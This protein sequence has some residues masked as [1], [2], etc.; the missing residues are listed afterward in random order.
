MFRTSHL[1]SRIHF[2][3]K[4]NNTKFYCTQK[5]TLN[6]NFVN[7]KFDVK[8]QVDNDD[9]MFPSVKNYLAQICKHIENE[10][11]EITRIKICESS[12]YKSFQLRKLTEEIKNIPELEYLFI[13]DT[14]RDYECT[15]AVKC[16]RFNHLQKCIIETGRYEILEEY[17][18]L[19]L[20]DFPEKLN[21]RNEIGM[22]P[23][24]LVV[25][26]SGS[27]ST[28]KTV[29]ILL[30]HNPNINE[31]DNVGNTSL[32]YAIKYSILSG[33][34]FTIKL[35]L[36]HNADVNAQNDAGYTPLMYA[37][38]LRFETERIIEL[39]LAHGA[40]INLTNKAQRTALSIGLENNIP[41]SSLILLLEKMNDCDIEIYGKKL[42]KCIKDG[43]YSKNAINLA[44]KKCAKSSDLYKPNF[45]F[46]FF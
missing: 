33:S 46:K 38:S 2:L 36:D 45:L 27:R 40:N 22:T 11:S 16:N 18:D 29:E 43:Y 4:V 12:L 26:N 9:N 28:E 31:I 10:Q 3:N 35:L 44:I 37:V 14:N 5:D 41:E 25:I 6:K 30:K 23:L 39:L 20:T 21:Y 7:I 32:M 24:I 17:I 1:K 8:Y 13:K 34:F 15:S 19:Y 42:I